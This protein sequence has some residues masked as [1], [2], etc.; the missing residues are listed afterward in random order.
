MASESGLDAGADDYMVKPFAFAEL[1]ARM[2]VLLRRGRS[3]DPTPD[4]R[5]VPFPRY[6]QSER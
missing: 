3:L 5:R 4:D 6:G 2:R 1:L